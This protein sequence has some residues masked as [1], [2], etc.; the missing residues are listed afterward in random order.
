MASYAAVTAAWA[1]DE[2]QPQPNP[3]FL[4]SLQPA[5]QPF[6][7]RPL[8]ESKTSVE[9]TPPV[10]PPGEKD[11]DEAEGRNN[12][13]APGG[14]VDDD[15]VPGAEFDH[16]IKGMDV[17]ERRRVPDDLET[18]LAKPYMARANIAATIDHPNGTTVGGWAEKHKDQSVLRQ[19]VDFFLRPEADGTLWPLDTWIGFRRLGYSFFWCTFAMTVI[20][21]FFS[22]FTSSSWI[23]DPFLRVN[24]NNGHRAKHG[25]D[26]GVIDTEGRFVPAKFEEI[27]AKFDEDNKG[28]LTFIEGVKM[29]HALRTAVDPIGWGAAGFE[30][31]STYFLVWPQDGV[32]DKESIRCVFDGS[33]FYVVAARERQRARA[34][35]LA[36]KQMTWGRWIADSIPGPWRVWTRG[37]KKENKAAGLEWKFD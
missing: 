27:F 26:T 18:K 32:V 37:W 8:K 21:V 12:G 15:E 23:P 9:L 35:A 5:N 19:H 2:P 28:G 29:V 10:T 13:K 14:K 7:A 31:A 4:D 1:P 20:H 6:D 16:V 34:L 11:Q 33:I 36:R 25:S 24:T 30:W 3:A 17:M 22:W